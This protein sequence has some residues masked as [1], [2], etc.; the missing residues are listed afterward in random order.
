MIFNTIS[1]TIISLVRLL[2]ELIMVDKQTI[3]YAVIPCQCVCIY[4]MDK[5]N[6]A[7]TSGRTYGEIWLQSHSNPIVVTIK[8]RKYLTECYTLRST[9]PN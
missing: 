4:P 9:K 7:L 6:K 3:V 1:M 5:Q 8:E 2:D